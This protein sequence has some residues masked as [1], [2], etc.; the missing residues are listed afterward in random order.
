MK[1]LGIVLIVDGIP[2]QLIGIGAIMAGLEET[3]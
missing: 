1:A 3:L 2:F